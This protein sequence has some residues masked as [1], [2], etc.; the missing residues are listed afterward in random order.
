MTT[1][2]LENIKSRKHESKGDLIITNISTTM[3]YTNW[4]VL[5]ETPKDCII[6]TLRNF[7]LEDQPDKPDNENHF[8]LFSPEKPEPLKPGDE[9]KAQLKWEGSNPI[10]FSFVTSPTAT[11]GDVYNIDFQKMKDIK[12]MN[13]VCNYQYSYKDMEGFPLANEPNPKYFTI[14]PDEGMSITVYP[15]DD[16]FKKGSNTDARSEMRFLAGV[17]DNTNYRM[18]WTCKLQDYIPEDQFCMAQVFASD[19]PNIMFRYRTG[20]YE[21]L[22]SRGNNPIVKMPLAGSPRT[23]LLQDVNWK[24]DFN[25]SSDISVGYVRLYKND[26]LVGETKGDTSGISSYIKLGVYMQHQKATA[27][28][29]M[30]FRNLKLSV[31]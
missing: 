31:L 3:T 28:I 1:V 25:L 12:E 2:I 5:V 23:D 8:I 13:L 14:V 17:F 30:L 4:S 19:G 9:I 18:E 11:P 26:I 29:T 16:P 20:K 10:I 15:D 22:S 6:D 21:L 7:K 27:S 24:M